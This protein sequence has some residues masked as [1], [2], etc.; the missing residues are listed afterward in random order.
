MMCQDQSREEALE[1]AWC[2]KSLISTTAITSLDWFFTTHALPHTAI[3]DNGAGFT[4]AG[5]KEL[6]LGRSLN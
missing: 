3:V 1:R 6:L 2:S 5:L 4:S